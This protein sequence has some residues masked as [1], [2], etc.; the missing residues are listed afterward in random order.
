MEWPAP[1]ALS[2]NARTAQYTLNTAMP[3]AVTNWIT[4]KKP[5]SWLRQHGCNHR[6]GS[7]LRYS[8][9]LHSPCQWVRASWGKTIHYKSSKRWTFLGRILM[10]WELQTTCSINDITCR[11][12]WSLFITILTWTIWEE[13]V[14]LAVLLS[15]TH[16]SYRTVVYA[17]CLSI[18]R[19]LLAEPCLDCL[20]YQ[21]I[22]K[23][24]KILTWTWTTA[25]TSTTITVPPRW[26]VGAL[27][28]TCTVV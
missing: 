13:W 20:P 7:T 3:I 16:P 23:T 5:K 22:G 8:C 9:N 19:P 11:M 6:H 12:I 17:T 1:A 21:L 15:V 14:P 18:P 24:W 26:A 2:V 28:Q 4:T 10:R 27:V 25:L